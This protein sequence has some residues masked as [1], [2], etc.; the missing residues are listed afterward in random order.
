M[1]LLIFHPILQK[2]FSDTIEDNA[3]KKV[4]LTSIL[5][6]LI[7]YAE[8]YIVA[9]RD[10]TPRADTLFFYENT[11]YFPEPQYS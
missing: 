10:V 1:L 3:L 7:M 8:A 2:A 4:S 6:P 9:M 5:L 11:Y